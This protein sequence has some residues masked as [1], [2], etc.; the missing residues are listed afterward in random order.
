MNREYVISDDVLCVRNKKTGVFY[1]K[2]PFVGI[3]QLAFAWHEANNAIRE[4]EHAYYAAIREYADGEG[5]ILPGEPE[6]EELKTATMFEY[7]AYQSAKRI[8]N[9]IKRRLD[10]V[11]KKAASTVVA[12]DTDT[13]STFSGAADYDQCIQFHGIAGVAE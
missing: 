1:P 10:N 13:R 7:A 8:A 9:N 5:R 2:S 11:C 12:Y 4:A 3:G 6:F